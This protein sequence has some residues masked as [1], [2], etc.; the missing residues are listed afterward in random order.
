LARRLA[1]FPPVQNSLYGGPPSSVCTVFFGGGARGRQPTSIALDTQRRGVP[2]IGPQTP[3]EPQPFGRTG[4]PPS[5]PAASRGPM[6][7]RTRRIRAGRR[8]SSVAAGHPP[9]RTAGAREKG[10][11]RRGPLRRPDG[12]PGA[13]VP[14]AQERFGYEIVTKEL[15]RRPRCASGRSAY[16]GTAREPR[17]SPHGRPPAPSLGPNG[18]GARRYEGV[19]R[20]VV[21]LELLWELSGICSTS[22]I[23]D[24]NGDRPILPLYASHPSSFFFQGFKVPHLHRRTRLNLTNVV[25]GFGSSSNA[26]RF[27]PGFRERMDVS[28][29]QYLRS[30]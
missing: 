22:M 1:F 17:G 20:V 12:R 15:V 6:I 28:C 24:G 11:D 18:D 16:R 9:V 7:P 8:S 23:M 2:G 19:A 4:V 29:L 27:F 10:P 30:W 13:D 21:S 14:E 26:Q 5:A 3:A 25:H